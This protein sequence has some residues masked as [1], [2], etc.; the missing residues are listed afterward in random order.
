MGRN[1]LYLRRKFG[2]E[3]VG[4]D[5]SREVIDIAVNDVWKNSD[6]AEF[7]L[8]NVLTSSY[9]E[10]I[11]DDWFDL[12]ITRWLLVGIPKSEQKTKFVEQLKRISKTLVIFEPI[13]EESQGTVQYYHD[14]E[15]CLSFDNWE[16]DYGL[17]IFRTSVPLG[18]RT[19][20]IYSAKS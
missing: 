3:V 9:Y 14:G 4:M 6:R 2:S 1:L 19:K 20:A 10:S 13:H 8:D 16:E 15:Y 5:I 17:K 18:G 11:E 7:I 12:C